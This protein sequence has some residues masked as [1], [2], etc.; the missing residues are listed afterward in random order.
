VWNVSIILG[1]FNRQSCVISTRVVNSPLKTRREH[2]LVS[3]LLFVVCLLTGWICWFVFLPFILFIYF[4]RYRV[5]FFK[6]NALVWNCFIVVIYFLQKVSLFDAIIL[7]SFLA[8][9]SSLRLTMPNCMHVTIS[10]SSSNR[11]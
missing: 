2:R 4:K 11:F 7:S 10:L 3:R 1:W 8:R 5:C 9:T 6:C